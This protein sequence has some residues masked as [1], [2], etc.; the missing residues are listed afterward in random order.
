M[1]PGPV[2]VPKHTKLQKFV[3]GVGHLVTLGIP[4]DVRHLAGNPDT[5]WPWFINSEENVQDVSVPLV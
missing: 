5:V 4:Q 3:G 2:L 1:P